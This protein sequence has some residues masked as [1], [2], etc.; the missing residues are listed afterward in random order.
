[1]NAYTAVAIVNVGILFTIVTLSI[2]GMVFTSSGVGLWSLLLMLGFM[3][4]SKS[5]SEDEDDAA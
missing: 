5:K 1:M 2:A 4:T 3:S